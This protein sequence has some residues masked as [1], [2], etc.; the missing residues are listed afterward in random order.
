VS[1]FRQFLSGVDGFDGFGHDVCDGFVL[2]HEC[3]FPFS[4]VC[5]LWIGLFALSWAVS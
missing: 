5:A 1:D 4:L 3:L 2:F